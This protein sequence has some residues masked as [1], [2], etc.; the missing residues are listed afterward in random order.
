MANRNLAS[1]RTEVYARMAESGAGFFTNDQLDQWLADGQR[2]VAVRTEP[3]VT[4]ATVTTTSGTAEYEL[5][6]DVL[7]IRQVHY[8]DSNSAWTLLR[9]TSWEALFTA[10]PD[11]ENDTDGMPLR[12]YWRSQVLG[13]YPAP[14]ATYAGTDTL[15]ILYTYTPSPMTGDGDTS[16][17]PDWLDD[18]IILFAVYRALLKDR[19]FQRAQA[20]AQEYSRHVSD[21]VLKLQR[22][23]REMAPRLIPTQTSYRRFW[24][25]V[26]RRA[27][28][29][30]LTS[31]TT[32]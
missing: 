1:M 16:G 14:S 6:S 13:L 30:Q 31:G 22:H 19:D 24:R 10:S 15:R 7:S 9:E 3:V 29:V 4:T 21:A 18:A 17:L 12:W 2:D 32:V 5:P 20:M 8:L 26:P 11:F 28:D 25:S 27:S 23:R